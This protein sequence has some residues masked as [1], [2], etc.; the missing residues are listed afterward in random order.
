MKDLDNFNNW[1]IQDL[2]IKLSIKLKDKL[3]HELHEKFLNWPKCNI[4]SQK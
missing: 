1:Y 3:V 2:E 4:Y